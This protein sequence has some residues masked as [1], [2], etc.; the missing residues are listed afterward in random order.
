MSPQGW[1]PR[2]ASHP[3][4]RGRSLGSHRSASRA[5]VSV[6]LLFLVGGLAIWVSLSQA[7]IP[8]RVGAD[9]RAP[10]RGV[11]APLQPSDLGYPVTCVD[12]RTGAQFQYHAQHVFSSGAVDSAWVPDSTHICIGA[13]EGGAQKIVGDA[14]GGAFVAWV[15]D[16]G[17]VPDIAV[18][19]LTAQGSIAA[20]WPAGGLAVCQAPYSQ[21]QLEACP[22]QAGGLFATWSDFRSGALPR[23]YLQRITD[24]ASPAAGWPVD[25]LALAAANS[26][27][28]MP[29]VCG[30][31]S[32]GALVA[33][34]DRR[35]GVLGAFAQRVSAA[36][37]VAPGWPAEGAPLAWPSSHG[38]I[39]AV[40]VSP[41]PSDKVFIVWRC[42]DDSL[43]ASLSGTWLSVASPPSPI[44]LPSPTVLS[45]GAR[46]IG[47]PAL[48]MVGDG[49][50]I[51]AWADT[52]A[53]GSSLRASRV[54]SSGELSAGFPVGGRELARATIGSNPPAVLGD[55]LGNAFLAWEVRP[56]M[57]GGDIY[58]SRL[59][60]DGSLDADWPL[61]GLAVC[62]ARG[63][64]SSP[65]LAA[66]GNGGVV[67]TWIDAGTQAVAGYLSLRGATL[68][69]PQLVS[70]RVE[71]G[72]VHLVWKVDPR[73]GSSYHGFRRHGEDD[74]ELIKDLTSDAD[75]QVTLDDPSPP[76]AQTVEYRLGVDH[77][78]GLVPFESI[79][80]QVPAAPAALE[81]T[82]AWGGASEG[83][84]WVEFT[85][86]RGPEASVEL[87]D[88]AGRRIAR[89]SLAGLAP[90]L[91]RALV[92]P[93]G[94]MAA[95]VYFARLRQGTMIRSQRVVF[96]H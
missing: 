26:E 66:D 28:I 86:P 45:S 50:V 9:G 49:S 60:A 32:G 20:G 3:H 69:E 54:T 4:H 74:W 73:L 79:Q 23:V 56:G 40:R 87:I 70:S 55:G 58:A 85:L 65:A 2:C 42:E 21:Y 71:S 62:A 33:W 36:G 47:T 57:D 12:M 41:G 84:I 77:A 1:L 39:T 5:C 29:A 46:R 59:K 14:V 43:G 17:L 93:E 90:G 82:R 13:P 94:H 72:Q 96:V 61:G 6:C 67:A 75:Q 37:V 8:P 27:Q 81:I 25:G 92:R 10:I 76:E 95:G 78:G 63:D 18:Q 22:D 52:R 30:D 48:S 34:L 51:V 91:R 68:P 64:Q 16:D 24:A 38:R 88:I 89:E 11:L 53:D 19:R 15:D 7:A 83:G 35:T 31:G 44:L 80:V